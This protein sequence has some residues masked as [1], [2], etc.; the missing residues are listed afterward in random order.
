MQGRF[1][2]AP[3]EPEEQDNLLLGTCFTLLQISA[4]NIKIHQPMIWL[5]QK[6]RFAFQSKGPI[7]IDGTNCDHKEAFKAIHCICRSDS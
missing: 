7:N 2:E 1:T 4:V 6:I 5:G 3:A